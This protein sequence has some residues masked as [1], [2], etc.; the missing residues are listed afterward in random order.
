MEKS[1]SFPTVSRQRKM[2]IGVVLLSLLVI[3]AVLSYFVSQKEGYHMDEILSFQLSNAEYNPWIVPIQPV[4]RLAKFLNN[5]IRRDSLQETWGNMAFV[6]GD[7]IK[8]RR[9]SLMLSYKADVYDEPVW[10]TA[11]QFHDYITVGPA[12]AFNYLSVYFN[13]KDDNHPPVHFM[14]LHTVSSLWQGK[15]EPFMGCLINILAV[16]GICMLMIRIG[17]LL[18]FGDETTLEPA[19]GKGLWA[20]S[21]FVAGVTAAL[22][23]GLSSGAIATVLLVRMYA[24]MTFFCVWLFYIHLKKYREKGFEHKNKGLVAVTVLGFLTQYFF[25]FYCLSL[26]AV[27]ILLLWQEKRKRELV[28]YVRTMIIAAVLGVAVFPFAIDD[29]LNSGRGVEAW[30]NFG[31]SSGYSPRLLAFGEILLVRM[32]GSLQNALVAGVVLLVSALVVG[33]ATHKKTS[34]EPAPARSE[35]QAESVMSTSNKQGKRAFLLQFIV[36]PICYF[37]LAAKMSPYLIDRYIMPVFAFAMMGLA[38][39]IVGGLRLC[40]GQRRFGLAGLLVLGLCVGNVLAYDGQYLYKGYAAQEKVAEE[41]A[42]LPCVCIYRGYD[43]Y[44]N[45]KEFTHY[46]KTLLLKMEEL[47]G[48]QENDSLRELNQVV[49]LMKGY[50]DEAR[51]R[52]ILAEEYGWIPVAELLQDGLHGDRLWLFEKAG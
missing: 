52:E 44:N 2:Q 15:A 20:D 14:L 28:C 9:N 22:L 39:L 18:P 7:V 16:L 30:E 8:N 34:G 35:G 32:F 43:F 42:G 6:A 37:L 25:L 33:L 5:E 46:Q 40:Q 19:S 27:N 31:R 4:G 3:T 50:V 12:D 23:Y 24:T 45:V 17:G 21:R 36:P 11:K 10:I 49:V 26:A 29:V 48:R 47:E 51:V 1:H 13:V 38:F 41:Y